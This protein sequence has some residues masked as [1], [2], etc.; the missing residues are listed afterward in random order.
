MTSTPTGLTQVLNISP[1]DRFAPRRTAAILSA[2]ACTLFLLAG[3]FASAEEEKFP[4]DGV[5]V[6][7]ARIKYIN[8]STLA[9][10]RLGIIRELYFREGDFV[11]EGDLL[12]NLDDR[13]ADAQFNT[14]A[15]EAKNTV[16]I[17]FAIASKDLARAEYESNLQANLRVPGAIPQIEVDRLKLAYQR[18]LL[19]IMQAKHQKRI[20]E[21]KRDEASQMKDTYQVS[22][23]FQGVITKLEK[24]VGEGV[25]EGDPILTVSDPTRVK[26]FGYVHTRDV[27]RIKQGD[28]VKVKIDIPDFDI[29]DE[30]F[31]FDGKLTFIDDTVDATTFD[32]IEVSAEVQ[33]IIAD[34]KPILRQGYLVRMIILTDVPPAKAKLGPKSAMLDRMHVPVL[35]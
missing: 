33:N 34:G 14:A 3:T 24:N 18:S 13:V 29:P 1:T 19:Q 22:A 30:D 16:E 23:K 11:K 9:S 20:N 31:I 25:R 10:S 17:R 35:K 8:Y 21:L 4:S 6:S 28:P 15:E 2:I 5:I 26:V 12:L 27:H 32:R 7:D